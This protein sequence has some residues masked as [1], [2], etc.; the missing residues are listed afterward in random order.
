MVTNWD[1]I[2]NV[3]GTRGSVSGI[4]SRIQSGGLTNGGSTSGR[5]KALLP[6]PRRLELFWDLQVIGPFPAVQRPNS[7]GVRSHDK[8]ENAWK[9]NH[10]PHTPSLCVQMEF[11]IKTNNS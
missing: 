8:V 11:M 7:E 9:H 6:S 5:C 2:T 3:S 10:T 1:R 4:L